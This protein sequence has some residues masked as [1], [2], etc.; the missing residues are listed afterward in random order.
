MY[1]LEIS[2][3]RPGDIVF[4]REEPSGKSIGEI[5]SKTQSRM[6][7][8]HTKGNYSHVML[9]VGSGSYIHATLEG[10]HAGSINRCIFESPLDVMV[11]RTVAEPYQIQEAIVYARNQIGK[12][13]DVKEAAGSVYPQIKGKDNRQFCSRLVAQA[14]NEAG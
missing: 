13:Y 5:K 4:T 1:V 12:E 7:R 8:K 2:K 10:V 3:L 14:Y 6:I 11:L 9:Y